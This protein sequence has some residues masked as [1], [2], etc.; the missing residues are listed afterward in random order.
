MEQIINFLTAAPALELVLIFVSKVVEVSLGTVRGILINKGYRREGTLLSFFEILLWTFI[1]SRVIT[2]ITDAPI[3]GIVYSIGFSLGVYVGSR[4]ENFIALGKVLI[5]TIVAK[6]NSDTVTGLLRGKGYAVTTMD[7]HGRDSDKTVLMIFAN[8][9][10]KDEI[11]REIHRIDGG[12]MIITN[13]V[14]GLHGG[15]ISAARGLIK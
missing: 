10:G 6:E 11:I 2:G 3:K 8:R 7:A 4:I 14:S 15:T 13:D 9:K 5:Q 1:A 12:A